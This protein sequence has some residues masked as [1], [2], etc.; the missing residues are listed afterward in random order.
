MTGFRTASGPATRGIVAAGDGAT[1]GAAAAVLDAG[2]NAFDAALAGLAVAFIAEPV[3]AS[4]GG[5]GFLLAMAN[6]RPA[7]VYDFFAATPA[8]PRPAADLDF[9][10]ILV[11][12]GTATQEFHIG[13]GSIA[14][15]GTVAGLF[16]VHADLGRMPLKDILAPAIALARDG[17]VLAPMQAAV[18]DAVA[19][20]LLATPEARAVFAAPDAQ[21]RT[22]A[23]GQRLAWPALGD[24]LAALAAEGPDLFYRGEMAA[25]LVAACAAGGGQITAADLAAYR[26][27]RR[28]PLVWHH[29]GARLTT[30]PPP[31]AGGALIAHCLARL[32]EWDITHDGLHGAAHVA[33][34]VAGFAAS[35][36]V[37]EALQA[38]E[39]P[40]WLRALDGLIP[41]ARGTT[42][43][44]VLDRDGQAASL[45][46]SNGEGCGAV[47]PAL[48][49]MP[50]NMLGE[51]DLNP[52]GFQ[53]WTGG[54]RLSSMM[55]P[56]V[57]DR[58]DGTRVVLGSG[59]SNRIRSALVQAVV[60]L[61]DFDLD[62]QAA[63]TAPRLH[64]EAGQLDVEPGI[65]DGAHDAAR[66]A[67][68]RVVRW[69]RTSFFFG[70]VHAVQRHPDG[71]L[72]GAGD[73]RRGGCVAGGVERDADR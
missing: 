47:L 72:C 60:N 36:Q 25:A 9:R 38:G 48:G 58:T 39:P 70:G 5:G 55:A 51:Q 71:R 43:I 18:M 19:P 16:A 37:R 7:C 57:L 31:A 21:D 30:N 14:V 35:E 12:F 42:Q 34:L 68:D 28:P 3:L 13:L 44:S 24:A 23:G 62:A 17:T 20:I 2:G 4:L 8:R 29:R 26:V 54:R 67:A 33:A 11:D 64:L 6:G 61:V 49:Y 40:D 46:V 10:P 59:G 63:V 41:A 32:A 66:T 73:P 45:T 50:N 22:L 52:T 1:A 65:P 27:E 15:P 56:S 69:E 53:R